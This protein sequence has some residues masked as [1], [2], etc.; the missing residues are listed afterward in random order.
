MNTSQLKKSATPPA[1]H[2][3]QASQRKT[4]PLEKQWQF[5]QSSAWFSCYLLF[6]VSTCASTQSQDRDCDGESPYAQAHRAGIYSGLICT[7]AHCISHAVWFIARLPH[8]NV[9]FTN[10]Q[11]RRMAARMPAVIRG[12][13]VMQV[14]SAAMN[15]VAAYRSSRDPLQCGVIAMLAVLA[16]YV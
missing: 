12:A 6:L 15:M 2:S 10:L 14:I 11:K 8:P 9:A 4:S 16:A 13:G 7:F 3:P 5:A 1:Q